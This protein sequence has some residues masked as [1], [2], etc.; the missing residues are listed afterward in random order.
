VILH[1]S[2]YVRQDGIS[3]GGVARP[4]NLAFEHGGRTV[5]RRLQVITFITA[6]GIVLSIAA[7]AL[8][9]LA[10]S[11]DSIAY[12]SPMLTV[13]LVGAV[14]VANRPDNRV[15]YVLWIGGLILAVAAFADGYALYSIDGHRLPLEAWAIWTT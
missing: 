11:P 9:V 1:P 4:A 12:G 8:F 13:G 10:G 3:D 6:I 14:I 7:M 5:G 15:G 2:G